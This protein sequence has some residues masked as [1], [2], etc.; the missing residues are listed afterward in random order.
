MRRK[1]LHLVGLAVVTM[2]VT[3]NTAHAEDVTISTATTTPVQTADPNPAAPVEPGDVTVASGG[4]ITVGANQT[5]V[6]VNSNNDVTVANGGTLGSNNANNSTGI[7]VT[8]GQTGTI[9]NSGAISLLED[10]TLTDT[11]NDGDMDGGFAS[12]SSTDRYGIWVDSGGFTGNITSN[13]ITVEGNNSAGIRVDG[14]LTG[15]LTSTGLVSIS[16]DN[17]HAFLIQGG[18]TEGID[19]DVIIRGGASVQG[20]NSNGLTLDAPILNG[21]QL[22]INGGWVVT[23]FHT[24]NRPSNTSNF[25]ADD[26]QNGGSALA[27]H[28][29]VAGGVT[30]EGIGV[31]DDPD[32]DGDG[33]ENEADDN[34]A[35]TLQVFGS[36]P[37]VWIAAD[38]SANLVLGPNASG[39]GFQNRGVI[40]AA[41][42]YDGFDATALRI[43]GLGGSTAD[44]GSVANDRT[45]SA[46][47]TE[48]DAFA[49]FI[50]ANANVT[51]LFN[52]SSLLANSVSETAQ[53][54]YGVYI[55]AGATLPTLTNTGD[56]RAHLFG[57]IGAA[58]AIRDVSGTLTTINNSGTI[59]ARLIATDP[60]LTDDVVP[61]PTGPAVAIDVS[62]TAA[63]VTINQTA[64]VPFTDDDATDHDA[65]VLPPVTI[66]GDILLGSGA[67]TIN[68]HAG[69]IVGDI[70][71]GAGADFMEIDN[72]ALFRGRLSDDGSLVLNVLDGTL[73]LRGGNV[74]IDTANFGADAVLGVMLSATPAESTLITATAVTFAPGA[75][76][77]ATVPVGL[78]QSDTITFLTAASLTG[79]SNVT[80]PISGAG[81]SFLYNLAIELADPLAADGAANALQLDFQIKTPGELGMT[82]NQGVAFDPILE[83]LR[84]DNEAALAFVA[85]DN[86]FDFFDAYEDL[87]PSYS[88]AA[89]E[90]A[91]TAIQQM[92]SA[93][94]NRLAATRLH[95]LN[96]VSVWAQEIA[97]GLTRE[98]STIQGQEYRGHGFGLAA[99]IDGPTNNGGLFGL[100]ASFITS[101]VE[102]PGRPEGEVSAS[103]VQGN[104]YYGTAMGPIDLDFVAGAGAG[105]LSSRRFVEIGPSFSAVSEADWWSFE[106]HGAVRASAPIRLAEWLIISPQTALTYV[107]L[108][109]QSYEEEGG[110]AA[111]D[112]ESD[113]VSSQRLWG[114]VGL[115]FSSRLR[116]GAQT[117]IAPRLYAGWRANLID[118]EAERTFR[119]IS[120]GDEFT[121][122][123][124]GLGDGGALVGIGIDASNGYSTFTLGY[125]GEFGDQIERHS[126]NAS[127]RFRF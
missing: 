4:S 53:S 107:Y 48:A 26:L 105:R 82:A 90:L 3:A 64:P 79:G 31:E 44:V 52:R 124:E 37:A 20:T 117:V 13:I 67:D 71:F 2:G 108:N 34:A 80:G 91:A 40:T 99:G 76:V 112:Y 60:D 59:I 87:M 115:E 41:G 93:T 125:E 94:T 23:G 56:L 57:E 61:V 111:I 77:V 62:G 5:A 72:G 75:S 58:T 81:S 65:N 8:G 46:V 85:L 39:F 102:E 89:T 9:A 113:S 114:D 49:I 22:R 21:G 120:T 29:G 32:D 88:S 70:S 12:A 66:Q 54:A 121:L 109:E 27:I 116:M 96:D 63:D 68:L 30:I 24:T 69:E 119:V 83:A 122:T 15:D 74:A 78:P 123:D 92:Q 84:Q 45:L 50:G 7:L 104:A 43:E 18:A 97:Y 33:T 42:V 14:L 101:E 35:G 100:S 55:D 98:P 10:Y 1:K 110:G 51:N 6:T 106:G 47:A 11:D 28:Y 36:S 118:E 95:D 17:S 103:F 16:G 126:L 38:P 73:D 127:V 25:D 19:G 86:E